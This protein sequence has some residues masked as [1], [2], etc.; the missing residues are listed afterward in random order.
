[1]SSSVTSSVSFRGTLRR[2]APEG[3]ATDRS[4]VAVDLPMRAFLPHR[5]CTHRAFEST[6]G[7]TDVDGG[8]SNRRETGRATRYDLAVNKRGAQGHRLPVTLETPSALIRVGI[9]GGIVFIVVGLL[10]GFAF[11][12]VLVVVAN[13]GVSTL[14]PFPLIFG[15]PL[16]AAGAWS[17]RSR[18]ASVTLTADSL[19]IHG[20]LWDRTIP[21][22]AI[23]RVTDLP[24][25]VWRDHFGH[26]RRSF[27]AA[28]YFRQSLR[29]NPVTVEEIARGTAI[30]QEWITESPP[31]A[32]GNTKQE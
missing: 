25:V 30:L 28:L 11:P 6:P 26:R 12:A 2:R 8:R 7:C 10:F 3:I 17:V 19:L 18:R 13:A 15:L 4:H 14:W 23:E 16:L 21:R 5:S 20:Q 29:P 32:Y 22:S 27:I 31:F 24:V 1:M 9:V